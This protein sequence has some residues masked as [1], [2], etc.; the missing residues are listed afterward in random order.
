VNATATVEVDV[1]PSDTANPEPT[2]ITISGNASAN[3]GPAG[4]AVP[5]PAVNVVD[6]GITAAPPTQTIA[7]GDTATFQIVFTPTTQYGYNASISPSETSSPSL[8]T[9]PSPTF[10]PSSVTLSGTGQGTTTLTIATVPRPVTTGS[11]F[12]RGSLYAAWLPI[13]GLSLIGLGIGAGS[14]RRRWLA[15]AV[16]GLIAGMIL[17]LPSCGS[18]STSANTPGGTQAGTYIITITGSAGTGASHTYAVH[19]VVN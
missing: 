9:S 17:L 6:F 13:G 12:R 5:Q 8:V 16:L 15:G 14:K 1:T 11:L 7:A 18:A 10:N 3:G 4:G 19:L 2:Q